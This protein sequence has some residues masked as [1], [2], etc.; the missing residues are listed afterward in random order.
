MPKWLYNR[1]TIKDDARTLKSFS[2]IVGGKGLAIDFPKLA[3]TVPQ[4]WNARDERSDRRVEKTKDR[5]S[6]SSIKLS[7]H[8]RS[9]LPTRSCFLLGLEV[10]QHFRSVVD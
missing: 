5:G 10:N 9:W 1:L 8:G 2:E 7:Q 6:T 4:T 3:K